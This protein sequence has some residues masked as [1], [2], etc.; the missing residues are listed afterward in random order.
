MGYKH[1]EEKYHNVIWAIYNLSKKPN[2]VTPADIKHTLRNHRIGN[3][4]HTALIKEKCIIKKE[5]GYQWFGHAPSKKS[6][7]EVLLQMRN[8]QSKYRK[9]WLNK[10]KFIESLIEKKE[11]RKKLEKEFIA[12]MPKAKKTIKTNFKKV[13]R[14]KILWGFFE[15]SFLL[16]K[17]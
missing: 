5:E 3:T 4:M 11:K 1:R 9:N 6:I 2:L 16:P 10:N 7:D 13:F 14:L 8:L 15:I 12:T 17:K